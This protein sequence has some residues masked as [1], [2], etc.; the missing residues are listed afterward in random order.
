MARWS[1]SRNTSMGEAAGRSGVGSIAS[2][3]KRRS[4]SRRHW[5]AWGGASCPMRRASGRESGARALARDDVAA[6]GVAGSSPSRPSTTPPHSSARDASSRR[7]SSELVTTPAV[8][9]ETTVRCRRRW[10][11]TVSRRQGGS[12]TAG[13]WY[14][15]ARTLE[16]PPSRTGQHAG[17]PSLLRIAYISPCRLTGPHDVPDNR[18]AAFARSVCY[19]LGSPCQDC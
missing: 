10:F 8:D 19:H 1:K 12:R 3:V 13:P 5:T 4:R 2:I 7:S 16:R 11:G 9:R 6:A 14:V 17:L 18:V 15:Q